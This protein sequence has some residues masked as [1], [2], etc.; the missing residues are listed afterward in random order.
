MA[1]GPNH[2][3]RAH[4]LGDQGLGCGIV[5]SLVFR[6]G[7]VDQI[8]DFR[9]QLTH[10]GSSSLVDTKGLEQPGSVAGQLYRKF[11]KLERAKEMARRFHSRRAT[12]QSLCQGWG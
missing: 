7:G 3:H 11:L 8:V 6:Q 12:F 4:S 5:E 9:R 10:K 1:F 2:A